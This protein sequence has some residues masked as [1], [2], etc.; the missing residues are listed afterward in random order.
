MTQRRVVDLDSHEVVSALSQFSGA[1][2][3]EAV[4][5][6]GTGAPRPAASF[7][8]PEGARGRRWVPGGS[9]AGN[10]VQVT[11]FS[12]ASGDWF[13]PRETWTFVADGPDCSGIWARISKTPSM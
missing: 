12:G 6:L 11:K 8:M 2:A 3:A 7:A 10:A 9:S 1:G 5:R 4:A 13:P